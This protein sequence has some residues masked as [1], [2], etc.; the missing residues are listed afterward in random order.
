[1]YVQR[2]GR[3]DGWRFDAVDNIVQYVANLSL[4]V[5]QRCL[6]KGGTKLPYQYL[7][8]AP[9]QD[10]ADALRCRGDEYQPEN[11]GPNP[12]SNSLNSGSLS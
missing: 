1:M 9:E 11:S 3:G 8:A 6:G 7:L 10:G 4:S 12:E 2:H 5:P